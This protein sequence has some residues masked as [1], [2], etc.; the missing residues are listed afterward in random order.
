MATRERF[1]F[2]EVSDPGARR[3]GV[4]LPPMSLSSAK[5]MASRKQAFTHT[6]LV[7]WCLGCDSRPLVQVAVKENDKWTTAEGWR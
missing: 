2:E 4:Y 7:I 6:A 1:Y 3:E 5:R